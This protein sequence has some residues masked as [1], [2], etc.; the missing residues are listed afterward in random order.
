MLENAALGPEEAQGGAGGEPC[1]SQGT[2]W[3]QE[4]CGLWMHTHS[5]GSQGKRLVHVAFFLYFVGNK[6]KN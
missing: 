4:S 6:C 5:G 1:V 3:K 2:C